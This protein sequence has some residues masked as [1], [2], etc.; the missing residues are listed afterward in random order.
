MSPKV[1]PVTTPTPNRD[2]SNLFLQ[3]TQVRDSK[4]SSDSRQLGEEEEVLTY[5]R[6]ELTSTWKPALGQLCDTQRVR[7]KEPHRYP[8]P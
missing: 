4:A 8:L 3:T 5:R 1:A 6:V 2:A 7:C